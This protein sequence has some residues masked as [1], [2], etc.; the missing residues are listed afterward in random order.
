[1][2]IAAAY[3]ISLF[4]KHQKYLNDYKLAVPQHDYISSTAIEAGSYKEFDLSLK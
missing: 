3:V 4:G 1:M 2:P